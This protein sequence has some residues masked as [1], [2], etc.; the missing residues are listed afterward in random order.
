[1]YEKMPEEE[2]DEESEGCFGWLRPR[3]RSQ[4]Q[5]K[6]LKTIKRTKESTK[7]I[8][9]K[10]LQIKKKIRALEEEG[11]KYLLEQGDEERAQACAAVMLQMTEQHSLYIQIW[12]KHKMLLQELDKALT[13]SAC[14]DS[15]KESSEVLGKVISE[16]LNVAN[17]DQ[18]MVSL[19]MQQ[20]DVEEVSKAMTQHHSSSSKRDDILRMWKV[21]TPTSLELVFPPL[22]TAK[23][24]EKE[25]ELT[26]ETY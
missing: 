24:K 7:S 1:M 25:E 8:H 16:N 11:K 6:I 19:E 10:A 12:T 14:A 9:L 20:R 15:L 17:I 18:M 22:P 21:E 26:L 3:G 13:L 4:P 2:H 5:Q 23:D